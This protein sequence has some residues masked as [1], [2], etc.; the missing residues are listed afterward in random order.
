MKKFINISDVKDYK[1][2][3]NEAIDV[4]NNPNKF[5]NI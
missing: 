4:K 3:G 5:N 2:L 1:S